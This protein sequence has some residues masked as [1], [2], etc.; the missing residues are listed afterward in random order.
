ML[1]TGL[2]LENIAKMQQTCN[3]SN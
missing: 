1:Y 2:P 3:T